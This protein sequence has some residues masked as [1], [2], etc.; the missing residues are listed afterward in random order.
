MP[1]SDDDFTD[2]I[3]AVMADHPPAPTPAAGPAQ[4]HRVL[5]F[6]FG[7]ALFQVNGIL[8]YLF[9]WLLIHG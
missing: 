3:T 1:L 7:L 4:P 6:A 5:W 9:R 2:I 8:L